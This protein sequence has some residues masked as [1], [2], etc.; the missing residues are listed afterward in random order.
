MPLWVWNDRVTEDKIEL[1]LADLKAHGMG[2]AFIHPRPGLI[3]PYL[4][5]E[6]LSLCQ[7]AVETG[8]KLGL[9][10]W[11][12]DENSYPSGFAGGHV[13]AE[14]PEATGQGLRMVKATEIP[15]SFAELPW[16]VLRSTEVGF[17]DITAQAMNPQVAGKL[18]K[19][20][21]YFFYIEK[22]APSPWF[23][24]FTYVDLMQPEV[25]KKFLHITLDA[26]KK[27]IGSEF[28]K[29]VPGVFQD[30]A[31][32]APV[33]GKNV[34]N[35]TPQLFDAFRKK[36]GYDLRF[37]L[38]SLFEERGEWK[39]VR[40]NFY[41]LLLDL[42]IEGWAKPYYEYCE[43]NH[44]ILTGHYWEHEWPIPRLSPDNMAMAGYAQMPGI[45]CLMNDWDTGPHA[46][47]GNARAVKEIRSVANQ[48]GQRRTLS[49]TY[50]AS[51]W[52]MT[53]A[54]QKRIADWELSLGINFINQHL[55]YMTIMGARKRDHPLSF[56]DHEPWWPAYRSLADYI[57]RLSVAM[58][59]GEQ[60]N[61]I[62]VLEPTTTGWMYYSPSYKSASLEKLGTSF[63][64][65]INRLEAEHIEYDLAS[66][67]VLKNHGRVVRKKL[68]VGRRAYELVVVPP[69]L[70][71]LNSSTAELLEQY[72][73]KGGRVLSVAGTPAFID[74]RSS[75]QFAKLSL[76]YPARWRNVAWPG[77]EEMRRMSPSDFFI[78]N[79]QG[80]REFFFH[81]R[82]KLQDG[83]LVFLANIHPER[84]VSARLSGRAGSVEKWDPWTGQTTPF[85]FARKRGK[86]EIEVE[87]PAGGS[88]L[89]LMKKA[90]GRPFEPPKHE[91]FEL[92]L[93]SR[94]EIRREEANVLT[95][96]YC[97]L[98]LDGKVE[99]DLYFYEAQ[100]K[101]F[102]RHGLDRNPW[103][104]AVQFRNRILELDNFP[105][106]S[107]FEA[108]YWFEIAPGVKL[109]T[110][111]VVIERPQ[112]GEVFVNGERVLPAE[113]R[114]WLDRAFGVFEIGRVAKIGSNRITVR[115]QPFTIF[116]ELEPVYLR[117]DFCLESQNKG[118]RVV[119]S[120]ELKLGLWSGQGLPFYAGTVSYTR[121]VTIPSF[122][123]EKERY[124]LKLGN[125]LGSAAE[126]RVGEKRAG[127]IIG[128]PFE[129]DLTDC[130]GAGENLV[131]VLVYGTLKNTLGPHHNNPPLGRA[132]PGSFQRGAE[133]GFP[134]GS[135]YHVVGYGLFEDFRIEVKRKTS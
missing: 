71:N 36:W 113:N 20:D 4:S 114:W 73:R 31:Q 25:T 134:S 120:K 42:F 103:D 82:R 41:A 1:Q 97:D 39:K 105:S 24:G 108:T 56:S 22:A 128:H 17:L 133:G 40:H 112:Y 98:R 51:G 63:Q 96:D 124:F 116:A 49:E 107:G 102:R 55:T 18:G 89:L 94:L 62:L 60:L 38:P 16:L 78:S 135:A 132:W 125:W 33:G 57:A 99:K 44:L 23:G 67:D 2:G 80:P 127:F 58:S 129:L 93:D 5:E 70:E 6:W 9:E 21:Y 10:I 104:S 68:I 109:D 88:L 52:D 8:K 13:P 29:T 79:I 85:P 72:L 47:F 95:L 106:S 32:I 19:G 131:S 45:D 77:L 86:A 87:L 7:H 26:Y 110:L 48:L 53:L 101:I 37:H 91:H 43:A 34:V 69:G 64:D 75:D 100:T 66:E 130:L 121:K 81:H 115:V 76:R 126:I 122:D 118:F 119:P 83:H 123:P 28:G 90:K 65:F 35:F 27:V 54:D 117:G 12:Y 61:R 14:M 74:G 50:G 92:E 30:E 11:L 84:E 111:E 15:A 3:T 46:Q 59:S